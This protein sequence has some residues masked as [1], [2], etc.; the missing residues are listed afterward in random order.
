MSVPD[1]IVLY[2]LIVLSNSIIVE[3]RVRVKIKVT[4][5]RAND[6]V[7]PCMYT[8]ARILVYGQ[9]LIVVLH[10]DILLLVILLSCE[11]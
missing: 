8:H 6:H 7:H 11:C 2:C 5:V 3:T 10:F 1:G 9:S 4:V